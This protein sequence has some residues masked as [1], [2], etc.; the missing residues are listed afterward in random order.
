MRLAL[1]NAIYLD[2]DWE[3]PFKLGE[4]DRGAF[5][6][7]RARPPSIS[8]IR[9]SR[10]A[11]ARAPAT[12]L[13]RCRTAPSTLSLLVV[14]PVRQRLSAMQHRLNGRGL[15]RIARDLAAIPVTLSL[16]RF[17]L[18]TDTELSDA[19]EKLGM[20]TAFSEAANFSRITSAFE[21]KIAFVKHAA[22]FKVDEGG[23]MA[24]A[25]TVVGPWLPSPHG[26]LRPTHP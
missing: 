12:G 19:L 18:N 5:T 25:A 9:P 20:P 16:P 11:T 6:G 22:D 26:D 21:L 8:C 13:S 1:A 2:A 24:A 3:H 10:C 4:P 7:L 23:T 17:H 15:A 14:L